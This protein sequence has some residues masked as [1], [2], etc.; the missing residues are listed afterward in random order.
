MSIMLLLHDYSRSVVAVA[1]PQRRSKDNLPVLS[2]VDIVGGGWKDAWDGALQYL[3]SSCC[4]NACNVDPN[5][6]AIA[7]AGHGWKHEMVHGYSH[8]GVVVA[9]PRSKGNLPGYCCCCW[10]WWWSWLEG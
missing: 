8:S 2:A 4:S 5:N 9:T 6:V 3:L 7:I 1:T 10:W